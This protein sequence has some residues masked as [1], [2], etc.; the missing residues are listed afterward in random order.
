[1]TP[2]KKSIDN[3]DMLPDGMREYV[4]MYGFHFSKK[5]C[6]W[7]VSLMRR[8]D[9][10]GKEQHAE[11]IDKDSVE[12]LLRMH[13][14]TLEQP[15][16]YDHVYV[17]NMAKA[18]FWKSSISDEAHLALYVKDVMEDVDASDETVFRQWLAKMVG[19]G[20]PVIWRDLI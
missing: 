19:D 15:K 8:K 6:E 4:S 5:A 3:Y 20:M 16:G 9:K 12:E 18:D 11:M 14:V 10:D 2:M 7:A 13:G 1:M 17:A